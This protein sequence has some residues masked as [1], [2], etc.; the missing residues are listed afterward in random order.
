LISAK[1]AAGPSGSVVVGLAFCA[2]ERTATVP[3]RGADADAAEAKMIMS[4]PAGSIEQMLWA[5]A[6]GDLEEGTF[7]A[8]LYAIPDLETVLGLEDYLAL[9]TSDYR[10]VSGGARHDRLKTACDVVSRRF[11]RRCVCLS[12]QND[13]AR[14]SGPVDPVETHSDML[15]QRTPWIKLVHCRDCGTDWLIGVDTRDDW[16]ILHRLS[17]AEAADI[18][19]HDRWPAV[20]DGRAA[21]WPDD[22]WLRTDGFASLDAWR[23][24]HDP[25]RRYRV[26][27]VGT[28]LYDG[29][30]PR[31]IELL[32]RPAVFS[33]SRWTEDEEA[34]E[35]VLDESTPVPQTDDGFVY[36]VGAT[37]GGEFLSINDAIAWAD[38][39]AW[40]PVEWVMLPSA[41]VGQSM[42]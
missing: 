23:A 41:A 42:T 27:A 17:A 25:L 34:G 37:G 12:V 7:E 20:F 3:F 35:Y 40:G 6:R 16:I 24:V 19:T 18:L 8:R 28:W 36:Y 21:L 9:V 30:I 15:A 5:Y 31:K 14:D 26:V 22:E 38:R 1:L 29:S 39:Q 13:V 4:A 33:S 10:K 32:A 2:L 11:P